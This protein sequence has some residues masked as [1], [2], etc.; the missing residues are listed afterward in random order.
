MAMAGMPNS[1]QAAASSSGRQAPSR[2]LNADRAWS[3]TKLVIA[4]FY[5]PASRLAVDAIQRSVGEGDVPF[6]ARP[7]IDGPPVAGGTPGA[8][9]VEDLPADAVGGDE[10][11]LAGSDRHARG[12]RRSE[13]AERKL[14]AADARDGRSGLR[15][16]A[17]GFGP[18]RIE[19]PRPSD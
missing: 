3:S 6:V 14:L 8:G 19:Q 15:L 1:A 2:K 12:P 5:E 11:R 16:H 9:E 18:M 17:P 7:G 13:H 4:A 10:L